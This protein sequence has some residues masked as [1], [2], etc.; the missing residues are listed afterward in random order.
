MTE[1]NQVQIVNQGQQKT[2]SVLAIISLIAGIS[3]FTWL[4]VFGAIAALLTGYIAKNDIKANP[5]NLDGEGLATAG[6]I[7]G[8]VGVGLLVLVPCLVFAF[9]AM[10]LIGAGI[11]SGG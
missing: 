10:S 5:A 8:W 9:V 11:F 1:Q 6:I 3:N 4:P 2:T 7:M